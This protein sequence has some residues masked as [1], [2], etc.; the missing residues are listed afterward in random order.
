MRYFWITAVFIF[1]SLA[2]HAQCEVLSLTASDTG[3]CAPGI[4]KFQLYGAPSGSSFIWN[5]GK[6]PVAGK[7]TFY[8]FY[9]KALSIDAMV[10]VT[11]PSGVKCTITEPGIAT[12]RSAP[13]P[14]LSVSRTLLCNGPDTVSLSTATP[15][16]KTVSW[17][18]DGVNYYNHG[19]DLVHQFQ[20]TG[21]KDVFLIVED[22]FGCRASVDRPGMVSV[23]NAV[24]ADFKADVRSGCVP[25]KVNY[26][27][28]IT[29]NGETIKT[30]SWTFEGAN[31]TNYSGEIPPELVYNTDG[32]YDASLVLETDRGCVINVL[33]PDYA[34]FGRSFNPEIEV[35]KAHLC[36]NEEIT[37][38]AKPKMPGTY[39]FKP[40]GGTITTV[41]DVNV[42][43]VA[44]SDSGLFGIQL[45]H[46]YNGCKSTAELTDTIL[47]DFV[48]ADFLLVNNVHCIAPHTTYLNEASFTNN[49]ALQYQWNVFKAATRDVVFT[50]D[51]SS[52]SIATGWGVFDV[53]LVVTNANGCSDT[54]WR[55]GHIRVDSI[56]PEFEA[57]PLIGCIG[58]DIEFRSKTPH[59]SDFSSDTF[60]WQW[61]DLD[62]KTV[63][64]EGRGHKVTFSYGKLGKYD[65]KLFAGNGVGC[66][67]TVRYHDYIEIV[68]PQTGFV[69]ADSV[70]CENEMLKLESTTEP[71]EADFNHEWLVVPD[72]GNGSV[73]SK[74]G[75][76]A[77]F[78]M[79]LAGVYDIW[80]VAS[81]AGGCRDTV[82]KKDAVIVNGVRA[83]IDLDSLNGC[84]GMVVN[85]R[86]NL[87]YDFHTNYPAQNVVYRWFSDHGA[88]VVFSN[89][90]SS[91]T[92]VTF[93]KTGTFR[94][95]LEV[96]NSAG[97]TYTAVSRDVVVGV[98]SSYTF[99]RTTLCANDFNLLKQ[100]ATLK[101]TSLQ[102]EITPASFDADLT[103]DSNGDARVKPNEPGNF[104]VRLIA[105][106]Y[107]VCADTFEQIFT[108][109]QVISS[110]T[111]P[112]SQLYCAPAYAQFTATSTGA[113]SFFWDFGDG[114]SVSTTG[115]SVANVYKQNSG[116]ENGYDIVLIS[117]STVGCS[118]TFVLN[119]GVKVVGPVP[120][121]EVVNDVGCSPLT[122]SFVNNS[123]NLM[124]YYLN[125]GDG[126]S[127]DSVNF[128]PHTYYSY[129][130]SDSDQ[131]TPSLYAVDS[132]GCVAILDADPVVVYR[133]PEPDVVLAD[134]AGCVPFH[135]IF[136][137]RSN[138]ATTYKWYLDTTLVSESSAGEEFLLVDGTKTL[139]LVAANDFGCVTEFTQ[140]VV[141]FAIPEAE[142]AVPDVVCLNQ[143]VQFG[144]KDSAGTPFVKYDWIFGD[145]TT[146]WDTSSAATPSWTY[147][148]PGTKM[149]TV[150]IENSNGC[151]SS[152]LVNLSL[153]DRNS[154]PKGKIDFVT[155]TPE[156]NIEV[157][158]QP[159]STKRIVA[160]RLYRD[161][162]PDPVTTSWSFGT[163]VYSDPLTAPALHCYRATHLDVCDQEGDPLN[164]HCPVWL[165]VDNNEPFVMTLTW[166]PYQ[167]W[168]NVDAYEVFRTDAKGTSRIAV[169]QPDVFT[170]RDEKRCKGEYTYYVVALKDDLKSRSNTVTE[171]ANY[172]KNRTPEDVKLAT[173]N[174]EEGA[175]E[176]AWNASTN[177]AWE[178]FVLR[179][180]DPA[181]ITTVLR[182]FEI[183]GTTYT[184]FNVDIHRYAYKYEVVQVDFCGVETPMGLPGT[185]ILLTG[186]YKDAV[187]EL[188]WTPYERWN[189]GVEKYIIQFRGESGFVTLA[190]VDG[191]TTGY[192]DA[193]YHSEVNGSFCY[194]I[195]AVSAGVQKDT[196]QSN[197]MCTTGESVVYIP[198]AFTPDNNGLNETFKPVARFVK[199]WDDQTFRD[200]TFTIY[201]RW[202][203]LVFSTSNLEEGWDG[204]YLSN[205]APA[206]VYMYMLSVTGID[207]TLHKIQGEV[208]LLR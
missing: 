122:V 82:I 105:G 75:A 76:K 134:T 85:A 63:L 52:D 28:E 31:L 189:A 62:D 179:K 13:D 124:Y 162:K 22:S 99:D 48:K 120:D 185:S 27:P 66:R 49:P 137:D 20:S 153:F 199:D 166:T 46:Q 194:R 200:Y 178:K 205:E 203:Q 1:T 89:T 114:T 32:K 159:V 71:V 121:F 24:Q 37:V 173:V 182:E 152:T 18:I 125:Y 193:A 187:T 93:N 2:A 12:V 112:D 34:A 101:P 55:Q 204:T 142:I 165:T 123:A 17:V 108:S 9:D 164:I 176:I 58:Q 50:S 149:V 83:E 68:A 67:D 127:L 72:S 174:N 181:D 60:F 131:F 195:L 115:R 25:Q 156:G 188:H 180:Y 81:I 157:Q 84:E 160:S 133:S 118:D 41:I 169:V 7:D 14:G 96:T 197:I 140:S 57:Q 202:G 155:F 44:Y 146:M 119:D 98:L 53:E 171:V 102:W 161:D 6:G 92:T 16:L 86:A 184:D 54:L 5:V 208:M 94:I 47:V 95:K 191:N 64:G 61:F 4:I 103:V 141:G 11:F 80:Y 111:I 192:M 116:W 144:L 143:P 87:L 128:G 73:R 207:G 196:S 40:E 135:L 8:G 104:S 148:T 33:K 21:T 74:T 106:K 29:L 19:P 198:N 158:W 117:K 139:K 42:V 51:K 39:Q 15:N 109:L 69:I 150:N 23:L 201:N 88:A 10:E 136:N 78:K 183:S 151:V 26:T 163:H 3:I 56:R 113:D 147:T 126:S 170:W 38:A 168:T 30:Y 59:S 100:N 107:G 138:N 79:S 65:V 35:S 154:I 77:D 129:S 70:L 132:L 43:N 91:S 145:E 36:P 45:V 190:E 167:G 206:G 172:I 90:S 110:F 97:C 130:T 175:V 186:Q 177:P